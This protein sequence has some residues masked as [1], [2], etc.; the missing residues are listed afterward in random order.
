M[1]LS[2]SVELT[3]SK[4]KKKRKVLARKQGD[5]SRNQEMYSSFQ[6][7]EG[8]SKSLENLIYFDNEMKRAGTEM[9][10]VS[11]NA[12]AKNNEFNKTQS[13]KKMKQDLFNDTTLS[14]NM[15]G[16]D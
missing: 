1:N 10:G 15:S 8:T 4:D 7:L 3:N 5:Q 12:M 14:N 6:K 9:K 13:P 16:T 11:R 2:Q